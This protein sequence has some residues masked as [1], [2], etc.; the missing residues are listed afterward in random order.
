MRVVNLEL[1]K[2]HLPIVVDYSSMKIPY[3]KLGTGKNSTAQSEDW[4]KIVDMVQKGH[5][6]YSISTNNRP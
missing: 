6:V 5:I 3:W 1:E 2:L 4:K